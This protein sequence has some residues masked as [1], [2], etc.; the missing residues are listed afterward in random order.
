[1]ASQHVPETPSN[2]DAIP[3]ERRSPNSA[4]TDR[5]RGIK[6][7]ILGGSAMVLAPLFGFLGGTMTGVG[8]NTG[9]PDPLAVW[10][11][12]GMIVG[13]IGGIITILGLLRW[14]RSSTRLRA[15]TS[16]L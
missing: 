13:G 2:T 8:S 9:G 15:R 6:M 4:L 5:S 3:P 12:G 10:L 16:E 7:A 14:T 11:L 1:M